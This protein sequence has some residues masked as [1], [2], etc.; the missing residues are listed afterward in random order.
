MATFNGSG[1]SAAS[2]SASSS[3]SASP[4][5]SGL[6]TTKQEQTAVDAWIVQKLKNEWSSCEF[7]GLLTKD[8]ISD[9][10]TSFRHLDTPIK[11]RLPKSRDLA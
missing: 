1:G 8:K 4:L 7:G 11:V 6:S 9:A 10:V 2:A 5:A 3:G